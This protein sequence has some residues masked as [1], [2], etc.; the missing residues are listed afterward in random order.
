MN[1]F[2]TD[3]CREGYSKIMTEAGCAEAA[4]KLTLGGCFMC[5]L[6]NYTYTGVS[7][8]PLFPSGCYV[9]PTDVRLNLDPT[10]A[11]YADFRPLCEV[12][13]APPKP[14]PDPAHLSDTPS[15]PPT[16]AMAKMPRAIE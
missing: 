7:T 8:D 3:S 12:T 4:T 1:D 5:Y 16:A 14:P 6:S 13:G 10:G 2:N 15:V 9:T 11:G